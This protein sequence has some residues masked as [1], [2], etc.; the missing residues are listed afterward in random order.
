MSKMLDAALDYAAKGI[1]VFP[2][3]PRGKNPLTAHGFKNATKDRKT[4]RAW[5]ERSPAAN[6]GIPTGHVS[7]VF[8]LDVDGE[9]GK[10][11][12]KNLESKF[13]ALPTTLK[14]IT[15]GGGEHYFF[16]LPPNLDVSNSAG[17]LGQGLDIRGNG[18]YVVAAPS[19]HA[20]GQRYRKAEGSA[21]KPAPAPQWL[22]GEINTTRKPSRPAKRANKPRGTS[23]PLLTLVEGIAEGERND[24]ITRIAGSLLRCHRCGL[25]PKVSYQLLLAFNDAR[26][27]PPLSH[28][29]VFSIVN[30]IAGAELNR[31]KS[32]G[33]Q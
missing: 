26:C 32:T 11:S 28:E 12:L 20:S 31:F 33:P 30:S 22:L 10:Q 2:V 14:I 13:G 7:G 27:K 15:G 18:G 6:I 5:W 21:D 25:D 1:P 17:R 3:V 16:Q 24:S 23:K 9:A 29:E 4:L 8:V 19:L